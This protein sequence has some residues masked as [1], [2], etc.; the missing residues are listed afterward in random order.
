M[1]EHALLI[2]QSFPWKQENVNVSR[3]VLTACQEN[4]VAYQHKSQF[5]FVLGILYAHSRTDGNIL[6]SSGI[7]YV[8]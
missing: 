4:P 7:P 8:L 2:L 3:C 5:P 1:I 6:G